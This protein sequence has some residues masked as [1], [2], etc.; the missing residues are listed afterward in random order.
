[1]RTPVLVS[2]AVLALVANPPFIDAQGSCDKQFVVSQ[3]NLPTTN[4]MS[5]SDQAIVLVIVLH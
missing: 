3:V 4:Q 5:P 2:I 1:M